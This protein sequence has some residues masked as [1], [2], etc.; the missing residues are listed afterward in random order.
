ML[1]NEY[2][3]IFFGELV[4]CYSLEKTA[5]L[6]LAVFLVLFALKST[7]VTFDVHLGY[8]LTTAVDKILIRVSEFTLLNWRDRD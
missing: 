8:V 1:F 6:R 2:L 5:P 4:T 3:R 7:L